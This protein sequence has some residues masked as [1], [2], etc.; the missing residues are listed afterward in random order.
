MTARK[1]SRKPPRQSTRKPS[2]LWRLVRAPFLG[3][4]M[5]FSTFFGLCVFGLLLYTVV[6]PP[7]TGVQ[8]QRRVEAWFSEGPYDKKYRPVAPEA[9]AA[10]LGHAVVAAEDGRFYEHGG[11]D[12][13]AV[14]EAIEE[15]RRGRRQRGASTI[16]QQLVKNLF[17]T[18]HRSWL[19]KGLEVPLAYLAE[20]ILSK[21]R[22]LY[23]YL[24]VIEWDHGV[25]GAEAAAQ[26]YYGV[27]AA[28]L[29][30]AQAAALAAD[31]P[32]PRQRTPQRMGRYRDIIL[33]RMRNMGW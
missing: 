7:T 25:Y 33:R 8:M 29:S 12:W 32:N 27:S 2:F 24:T 28:R 10:H 14:E 5:A 30:R 18:T 20:R 17:L 3:A 11:I 21:E 13:Q 16:T 4:L 1:R 9:I 31:I 23:L 26:H 6:P 22:I 19:R 15:G